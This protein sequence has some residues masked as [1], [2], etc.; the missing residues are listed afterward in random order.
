MMPIIKPHKKSFVNTQN[1]VDF[2]PDSKYN[3]NHVK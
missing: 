1:Y 3:K 2:L